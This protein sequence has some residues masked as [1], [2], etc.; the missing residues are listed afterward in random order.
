MAL[1]AN[2][3]TLLESIAPSYRSWSVLA[4]YFDGDGT[5]E[6]NIHLFTIEIRLAFDE[7]WKPHLEG[8][9]R[10]LETK[11]ITCGRVR[12]KES[13]NTWHLVISEI[14][15]VKRM[16]RELLKY[17]VKK[18]AELSAVLRYLN[19]ETTAEDF[20]DEM[21]AFVRMGERTGKIKGPAPPYTHETGKQ[22]GHRCQ[23]TRMT[24][25][26][27]IVSEEDK[28]RLPTNGRDGPLV[29]R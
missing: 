17:T 9:R 3:S 12:K 26:A 28:N 16:T 2:L 18:K 23:S 19:D 7:N 24:G 22:L 6:F 27:T 25:Q 4:G 15:S 14:S 21:N 13:Y 1:G 5:V 20:V 11:S 29:Q 8:I 10:F